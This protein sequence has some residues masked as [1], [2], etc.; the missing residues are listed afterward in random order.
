MITSQTFF[1]WIIPAFYFISGI[2]AAIHALMTK[3]DSATALGWVAVCIGIPGI[4]VLLYL[5]FGIN[6]I[7]MLAREWESKGM[8]NLNNIKIHED[9]SVFAKVVHEAFNEKTFHA[10]V[11]T[12][13]RVCKN[14]LLDGCR[15]EPLYDGTQAYPRMLAEID[16]AKHAV[17]LS[18]YIF[19]TQGIGREFIAALCNAHE[20]GVDVKVLIDGFGGLYALP[21]KTAYRILKKAKVPIALFLPPLRSLYYT[22]HF[23]LRNHHKIL[24]VDSETAFTGGMN[25]SEDNHA[26]F[27]KPIKIHDIHFFIK[28]P[29]VG[30]IQDVFL[31]DWYFS[32]GEKVRD[33]VY[34]DDAAKGQALC[35][36]VPVDPNMKHANLQWMFCAASGSADNHIRIMTPYLILNQH[37]RASLISA[38]LRGVSVEIILPENNNLKPVQWASESML[39]GLIDYGVKVYY[40]PGI[41]SHSKIFLVDDFCSYVGSA[42]LDTRSLRLNFEF[43]LEVYS[44]ILTADLISYFEKIKSES[45]P[46]SSQWL[47]SRAFCI[48][49]RNAF[50]R[51]FSPYL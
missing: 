11:N 49:L 21:Q 38:S 35:R 43:N 24:V 23:N 12:S 40:R 30:Q 50:F 1:N 19:N 47:Q 33:V 39:S 8:W 46:I 14:P 13:N 22:F 6:R 51:L 29:V 3:E 37:L 48:K 44:H 15:V 17:Y 25:I 28:G 9:R 36:G 41:F 16:R 32:T 26:D 18:T 27:D 31:R 7:S 45:R 20:R 5:L 34:F 42:N 2:L 10:L 4:G